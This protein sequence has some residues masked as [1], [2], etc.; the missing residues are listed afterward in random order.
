MPQSEP[1]ALNDGQLDLKKR[2]R[3]RLVGAA[4]LALLAVI[5]LPMVMD[6]QPRQAV[7]DL[8]V[9]IPSQDAAS[10]ASRILPGR[11]APSP[12]AADEAGVRAD[13][14][15]TKPTAERPAADKPAPDKVAS[16][17]AA[18][19][20]AAADKAAADKAAADKAAA[21][22][23]AADKAAADKAALDKVATEKAAAEKKAGEARSE[24]A[25]AAAALN[26]S[27]DGQ[28]LVLLGAYKEEAN[29]KQLTGKLK[30]M[31]L[32]TYTERYDSPQGAR[33]RVRCGP[34]KSQDAAEKAAA[35]IRKIGV[36]G[37]VAPAK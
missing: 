3:R 13:P 26:G 12:M 28:W 27:S 1:E 7:P 6:D 33:T 23:A 37:Q 36:D 21:D 16:D 22:K 9:K 2:S 30:Q 17:K 25:R 32:P 8:Q 24:A 5:V 34:F 19:D 14:A 29:V 11:P 4:A 18:A 10:V 20:K 15:A 31:G 35:R